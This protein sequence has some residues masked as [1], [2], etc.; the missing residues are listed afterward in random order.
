MKIGIIGSGIA[1]R[2]LA[3]AF[4]SEGHRVQ[5]GTRNTLKAEVV[6]FKEAN[7]LIDQW[8]PAFKLLKR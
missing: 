8:T 1:G 3:K 6:K 4:S 7:L 5:L 2:V